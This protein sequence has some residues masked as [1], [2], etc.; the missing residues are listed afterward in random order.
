MMLVLLLESIGYFICVE[1][2][3]EG[4]VIGTS[5]FSSGRQNVNPMSLSASAAETQAAE[6][7]AYGF[8]STTPLTQGL[9]SPSQ[10][11]AHTLL[12]DKKRTMFDAEWFE[13]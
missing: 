1:A 11:G 10:P 7:S 12:W 3:V 4:K 6:L 5:P 9:L 13:R 2:W 8:F